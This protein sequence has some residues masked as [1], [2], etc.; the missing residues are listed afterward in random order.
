VYIYA[1]GS[2]NF[3]RKKGSVNNST[4]ATMHHDHQNHSVGLHN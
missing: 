1:P 4:A 2:A 3:A